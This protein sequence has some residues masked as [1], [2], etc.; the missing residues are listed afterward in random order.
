MAYKLG[1]M[2]SLIFVMSVMLLGGDIV[3]ISSLHSS[4]DA[5]SLVVARSIGKEGRVSS[6]TYSLVKSHKAN[7]QYNQASVPAVGEKMTFALYKYY[8][9]F[10]LSKEKL[11]IT[12]TRTVIV[13]Y[14]MN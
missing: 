13:G 6:S 1:L 12:V 14:Y 7:I 5:L 8:N 11:K 4:L 9:S 10:V 3:A 2:L